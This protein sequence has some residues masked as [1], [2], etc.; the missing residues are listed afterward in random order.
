MAKNEQPTKKERYYYKKDGKAAYNLREPLSNIL[1]DTT[2]Y[3]EITKE[4]WDALTVVHAHEP[5]AEELARQAKLS[6]IASLKAQLSATDYIV[7]KIAEALANNDDATVAALKTEYATEL[8]NRV[9][10][11]ARINEL[12]G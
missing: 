7:I 8:A 6:E 11:R 3:E 4:E 10:W 2:G 5:S 12:E 9:S 1:S